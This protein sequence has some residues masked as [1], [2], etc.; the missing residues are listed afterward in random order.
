MYGLSL[1]VQRFIFKSES[2]IESRMFDF[3][4]SLFER[5]KSLVK[6]FTNRVAGEDEME[7]EQEEI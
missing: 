5:V 3:V 7:E 6:K 1:I 2:K 4:G